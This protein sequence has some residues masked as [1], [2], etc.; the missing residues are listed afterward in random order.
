MSS[1]PVRVGLTPTPAI[2]SGAVPAI[3]AAT[4]KNAADEK[5][6]GTSIRVPVSVLGPTIVTVAFS[7]AT[8]IPKAGS[9]RSV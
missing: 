4:M 6:P 9:I 8:G 2:R 3:K 7:R 5:S 1:S